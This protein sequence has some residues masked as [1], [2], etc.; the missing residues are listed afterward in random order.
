[1]LA[2]NEKLIKRL[3]KLEEKYDAQFK[4]VFSAIRQ[5]MEPQAGKGRSIGFRPKAGK[6]L[7]IHKKMKMP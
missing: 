7:S 4:I 1:M 6:G 3:D 2:S 5:L